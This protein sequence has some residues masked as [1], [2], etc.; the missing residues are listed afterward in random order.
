[1]DM[2]VVSWTFHCMICIEYNI[3]EVIYV[4]MFVW[5]REFVIIFQY[6]Q[7]SVIPDFILIF[8]PIYFIYIGSL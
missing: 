8:F 7:D 4:S 6:E 2:S 1:M 5:L 3:N